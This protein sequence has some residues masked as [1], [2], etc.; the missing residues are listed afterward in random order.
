MT[1]ILSYINYFTQLILGQDMLIPPS[2]LFMILSD[3]L[4]YDDR[5]YLFNIISDLM[6]QPNLIFSLVVWTLFSIFTIKLLLI[7]PYKFMKRVIRK[8][9][10]L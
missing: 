5:A 10:M 4:W 3:L 1:N 2:D 9:R 8:C 7:M 6:R